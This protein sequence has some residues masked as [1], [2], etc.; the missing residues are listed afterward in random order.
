MSVEQRS[1]G[2]VFV[3][4][5]LRELGEHRAHVFSSIRFLGFEVDY[6]ED[7]PPELS[8]LHFDDYLLYMRRR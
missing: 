5:T 3:S 4:S 7:W 8:H 6:M 1:V 2:I